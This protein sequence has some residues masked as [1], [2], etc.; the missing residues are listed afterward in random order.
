MYLSGRMWRK[1]SLQVNKIRQEGTFIR[2]VS[3]VTSWNIAIS[4]VQFALSPIITRLYSPEQYGVFAVFN[5]IVTNLVLIGSLRYN[6][7]IVVTET[8][9]HRNNAILLSLLSIAGV[10]FLASATVFLTSDYILQFI[11]VSWPDYLL[12]L[13]PVATLLGGGLEI[14][15]STNVSRKKF[16]NNGLSGFSLNLLSRGFNI[17]YALNIQ[18]RSIG[19]VWGDIAGKIAGISVALFSFGN[20][21]NRTREFYET[22]SW[23]GVKRVAYLYKN[24]PFYTLPTNLLLLLSGHLPIYFFQIQFT[25]QAVGNYALSSSLL[26]IVNRLIPYSIAG[27]FLP[28]AMELKKMSLQ[29]L[30]ES[31]YKLY[32]AMFW[33][34]LIIFSG[35]ALLG[36]IV[37]PFVFGE[38]WQTAGIYVAILSLQY[39]INF[40]AISL[41]DVYKVLSRQRIYLNAIIF[42]VVL[43]F[44]TL[45]LTT[46]FSLNEK[47]AL[48]WFCV[49]GCIGSMV[50]IVGIFNALNFRIFKISLSLI[51]LITVLTTI[52]FMINF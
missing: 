23:N 45:F 12:Y 27:V 26:E 47:Y 30:A 5:T 21:K 16:L 50:Q 40:I 51:L 14:L 36:K 7:A 29:H 48:L 3:I 52:I 49:A 31:T 11:G 20:L 10:S 9:E 19:L 8:P 43:K 2:Y 41:S 35:F 6:E 24:F 32:W 13:I 46:W 44:G 38:S 17:F 4:L 42:S 39:A 28:K 33:M 18:A 37:F 34:A 22:V 1:I 15:I 25:S